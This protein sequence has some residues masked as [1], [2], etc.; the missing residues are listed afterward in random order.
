VR[1]HALK[2]QDNYSVSHLTL[3]LRK[4]THF[5]I[6]LDTQVDVRGLNDQFSHLG[7]IGARTANI[8]TAACLEILIGSQVPS[9]ALQTWAPKPITGMAHMLARL[10]YR[11]LTFGYEYVAEESN[12]TKPNTDNNDYNGSPNKPLFCE[13]SLF[14]ATVTL[15]FLESCP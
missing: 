4:A 13:C 5:R 2:S 6:W 1:P 10:V 15:K 14:H 11:I 3:S 8:R 9:A 7:W 12:S